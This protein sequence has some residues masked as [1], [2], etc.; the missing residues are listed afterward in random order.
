MHKSIVLTRR[1]LTISKLP[2]MY[3]AVIDPVVIKYITPAIQGVAKKQAN[4]P[5]LERGDSIGF[6]SKLLNA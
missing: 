2:N 3:A 4:F 1:A 6:L 5:W